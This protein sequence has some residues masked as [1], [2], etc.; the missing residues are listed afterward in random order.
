ML[1]QNHNSV[2]S[3]SQN[4]TVEITTIL[5]QFSNIIQFPAIIPYI[6]YV[7]NHHNVS[8]ALLNTLW[9]EN[10]QKTCSIKITLLL[11]MKVTSR[12]MLVFALCTTSVT[13]AMISSN[14]YYSLCRCQESL[15]CFYVL[16]SL[17]SSNLCKK[18]HMQCFPGKAFS[19]PS[20]STGEMVYA[21]SFE[22]FLQIFSYFFAMT[23]SDHWNPL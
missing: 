20:I 6:Q 9:I 21:S 22:N 4:Y 10:T 13:R 16:L 5:N 14:F 8:T 2:Y 19:I 1:S 15:L 23:L 7:P 12:K 18:Q 3:W 17:P 11:A